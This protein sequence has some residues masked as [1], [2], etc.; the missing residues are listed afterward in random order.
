MALTHFDTI[1][2]PYFAFFGGSPVFLEGSTVNALKDVVKFGLVTSTSYA[3]SDSLVL[4]MK[5][6]HTVYP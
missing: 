5:G 1:L 2:T 4:F 6:P 3:D